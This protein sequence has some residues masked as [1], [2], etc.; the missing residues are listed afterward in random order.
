MTQRTSAEIMKSALQG[1]YFIGR[2]LWV[3]LPDKYKIEDI[4]QLVDLVASEDVPYEL[5]LE[6]KYLVSEKVGFRSSYFMTLDREATTEELERA[7]RLK[8]S[9]FGKE[10]KR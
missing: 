3:D 10:I 6:V 9:P 4:Y 2:N 8:E 7:L 5:H 1:R